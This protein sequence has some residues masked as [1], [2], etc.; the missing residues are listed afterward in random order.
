MSLGS[1]G[2]HLIVGVLIG[3]F[4]SIYPTFGS[5][6]RAAR[7]IMMDLGIVLFMSSI[8]LNA[9]ER[10]I[11][12]LTSIGPLIVA[13]GV[14]IT[15]VPALVAF[16]I[17]RYV[18]RMNAA[19]LLGAITGAMTSTPS[20]NMVTETAKSQIPALGYAG[21]YAFANVLLTFAGALLVLL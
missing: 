8:G 3:F 15:V 5:F 17:G 10:V 20:L 9:G 1:A 16:V 4:R 21:S 18:L 6:P 7:N 12:A 14:S 2:G 13:C 19:L 11:D